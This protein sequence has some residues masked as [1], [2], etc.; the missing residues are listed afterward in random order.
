MS[1]L[2]VGQISQS[3]AITNSRSHARVV[4]R[5]HVQSPQGCDNCPNIG[6]PSVPVHC[7]AFLFSVRPKPQ[8]L[9]NLTIDDRNPFAENT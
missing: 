3:V 1:R 4:V 6:S 7:V 5:E 9:A 8:P 2:F